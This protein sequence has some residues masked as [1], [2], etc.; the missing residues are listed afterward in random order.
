MLYRFFFNASHRSLLKKSVFLY[1]S[2]QGFL[3]PGEI[4]PLNR[5][6]STDFKP[7]IVVQGKQTF[8]FNHRNVY[9][10]SYV[11][12]GKFSRFVFSFPVSVVAETEEIQALLRE[13][14]IE[15]QTV[16]EVQPIRI[17]SARILSHIYV[18]LGKDSAHF[19]LFYHGCH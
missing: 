14:G 4:D 19:L 16:S 10:C 15:V 3:A 9:I 18:K 13:N 17:M 5:R 7:D 8:L 11:Q 12:I 6:F 1:F 2:N